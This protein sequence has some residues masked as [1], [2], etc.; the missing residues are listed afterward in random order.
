MHIA[1]E[2]LSPRPTLREIGVSIERIAD[3]LGV[4]IKDVEGMVASDGGEEG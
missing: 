3:E 4:L 1:D 2:S